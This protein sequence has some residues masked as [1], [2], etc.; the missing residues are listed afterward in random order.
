MQ[1][2][3]VKYTLSILRKTGL[4][5]HDIPTN[6]LCATEISLFYGQ[7]KVSVNIGCLPLLVQELIVA[8]F[9]GTTVEELHMYIHKIP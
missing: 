2:E 9:K 8:D 4:L 3:T 5:E 6:P 1:M 7:V